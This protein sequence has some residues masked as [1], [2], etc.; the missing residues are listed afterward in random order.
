MSE[1]KVSNRELFESWP[2]PKA[3]ATLAIPAIVSQLI[4][5]IYNLSDTYFIGR[6]GNPYMVAGASLMFPVYNICIALAHVFGVGGGSLISRLLGMGKPEEARRVSAFSFYG[7]IGI[8]LVFSVAVL[9]GENKLLSFLGASEETAVYAKQYTFYVIILGSLP[10]VMTIALNNIVRSIGRSR[11]AAFAT[12]FGCVL[13]VALD[14]LFMFVIL[15]EGHEIIGAA[16][17]TLISNCAS[18]LV[19]I[20]FMAV[21]SKRGYPSMSISEAKPTRSSIASIFAV[22]IPSGLTMFLFDAT[23]IVIDKLSS[24]HGDIAVA[25]I[26]IV[27]KAERV[28]LNTGIGICQGMMP[29]AGYNYGAGN[30]E[31]MNKVFKASRYSGIAFAL[32]SILLYEIFAGDVIRLFIND[33]ATVA[34]GTHFLRARCVA[35]VVMFMCF[36]YVHFFEGVGMG[37][38]SLTLAIVRQLVF[39]M[40]LLVIL[41]HFFGTDGIIWTQFIADLCTTIIS[42]VIFRR[43]TKDLK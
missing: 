7:S 32:I 20:G 35:T 25:A 34:M 2:V 38:V 27:L 23:N 33:P 12:S 4:L 31:R 24:L 16:V 43:V 1:E 17:A 26:G 9:L 40:P 36:N 19:F 11:E 15:P 41:N 22:G 18:A 13:N 6:T 39:N 14:P 8:S 30:Y 10:S 5:L 29:I 3:L 21:Y 37:K 28:P 42:Y